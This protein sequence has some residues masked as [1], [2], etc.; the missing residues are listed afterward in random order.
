MQINKTIQKRIVKQVQEAD[1][2]FD[3]NI[4]SNYQLYKE[5][6]ENDERN[7]R[8]SGAKENDSRIFFPL[9]RGMVEN[10]TPRYLQDF[11]SLPPGKHYVEIIDE[12]TGKRSDVEEHRTLEDHIFLRLEKM[13]FSLKMIPVIKDMLTYN[14]G[15][16]VFS[17]EQTPRQMDNEYKGFTVIRHI[18][19]PNYRIDPGAETEEEINFEVLPVKISLNRLLAE[20][21]G[22]FKTQFDKDNVKKLQEAVVK[23]KQD[24]TQVNIEIKE[25]WGYLEIDGMP[26]I[27]QAWLTSGKL[28]TENLVLMA[29]VDPFKN[30][31]SPAIFSTFETEPCA[32]LGSGLIK[33]ILPQNKELNELRNMRLDIL[34]R[35][36]APM[37][38]Y[39]EGSIPNKE[40]IRCW[41]PWGLVGVNS[42]LPLRDVIV[43]LNPIEFSTLNFVNQAIFDLDESAQTRT[44]LS[45]AAQGAPNLTATPPSAAE[46]SGKLSQNMLIFS[47]NTAR[48]IKEFIQKAVKIMLEQDK[49]ADFSGLDPKY[50][51][52]VKKGL[53]LGFGLKVIG[54]DPNKIYSQYLISQMG[55]IAPLL[56]MA[57]EA[58]INLPLEAMLKKVLANFDLFNDSEEDLTQAPNIQD[59]LAKEQAAQ[60]A[61]GGINPPPPLPGGIN[62]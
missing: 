51:E 47:Y 25:W 22:Q 48:F 1:E 35:I 46:F 18:H 39:A 14:A 26:R 23:S 29:A 13:K 7:A 54:V 5:Y 32:P 45:R 60:A 61:A 38:L 20:A 16:A 9:A 41:K 21:D 59:L 50:S 3:K 27:V 43:P 4:K 12:K 34:H 58:G 56:Q 6:Y 40:E 8:Y 53:A 55:Q 36:L 10:L 17:K 42:P 44:N 11:F 31:Q 15:V 24:P 19:T 57:K 2:H 49:V 52:V 62:G 30:N 33:A 28:L 37:Q